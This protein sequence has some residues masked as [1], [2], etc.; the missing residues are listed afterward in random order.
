V[1]ARNATLTVIGSG[2]G[3]EPWCDWCEDFKPAAP[4]KK[5]RKRK[6]ASDDDPMF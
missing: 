3:A 1:E 6:S 2:L 4:P 5:N